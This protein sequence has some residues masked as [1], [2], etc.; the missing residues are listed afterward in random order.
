M[1]D[2]SRGLLRGFSDE[3]AEL[4]ERVVMSTAIVVGQTK[5]FDDDGG[6]AWLYDSEHLVTN[7]HV[8]SDLVEPITVQLPN[9]AAV[10]ALL[11]GRDPLTDL[12][13]LRVDA[14]TDPAL[15]LAPQGAKLGELC[16][17]FGSPLGKFP[18]SMTMGIVSGL[19]RSLPTGDK[20]A[21]FDV[22]QIDAAINPGNS[23]GPLVNAEGHVI[24]VNTAGIDGADGISFAVPAETVADVVSELIE[25]GSVQRASLGVSVARR[26]VTGAPGG[27]ALIVTAV[28][29]NAAGPLEEGEVFVAVGDREIRTQND[30]LRAFRREVADRRVNV[31]VMRRGTEV[32][33]ECR[34]R[35]VRT[36]E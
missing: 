20:S 25:F 28:R 13:V 8:V 31:V 32:S 7:N 36:Y 33:I 23:G 29:A 26:A 30:L 22:I 34:P 2:S 27:Y 17:A 12:A 6:S 4:A 21:I 35:S 19:K 1:S 24:G 15:V 16:F 18:E 11:I 9:S 5:E 3:I 10:E 14:R